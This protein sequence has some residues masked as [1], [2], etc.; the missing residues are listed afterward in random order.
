MPDI[1]PDQLARAS[2][3]DMR[4]WIAEFQ[5][6]QKVLNGRLATVDNEKQIL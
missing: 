2:A 4:K 1:T 3:E 6:N 5:E